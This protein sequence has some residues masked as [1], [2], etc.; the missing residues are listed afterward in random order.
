MISANKKQHGFTLI[1]S[2]LTLFILAVGMLGVAGLQMQSLRSG[3]VAM[4]R[5]G[6]S[7]KSQEMMDR[8][9]ANMIKQAGISD[10]KYDI[11]R[12]LSARQQTLDLY[13]SVSGVNSP[14]MNGT[15]CTPD[16]IVAYDIFQWEREIANFLPGTPT[17]L[18][19]VAGSNITVEVRWEDR[20]ETYSFVVTS[21]I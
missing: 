5:M 6:V 17:S 2:L 13:A 20:G 3:S 15:V 16:Q 21:Q 4:Q 10:S 11:T 9:R 12:L 19:T 8:V 18:V 7:I 1:E 14:C